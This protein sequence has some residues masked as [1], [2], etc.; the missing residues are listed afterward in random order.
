MCVC[1]GEKFLNA[2]TSKR[3]KFEVRDSIQPRKDA[4]YFFLVNA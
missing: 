1:L 3:I 2:E 4:D